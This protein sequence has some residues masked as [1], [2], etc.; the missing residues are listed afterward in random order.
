MSVARIR[1][2][3]PSLLAP[4]AGGARSFELEAETLAGA[5]DEA[6]RLH[7]ALRARLFDE[8]GDFRQH[9]L[10]FHNRTNSRWLE[11]REIALADGDTITFMQAVSGG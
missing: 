3:L 7:P 10:C 9:V 11:S 4:I 5:L 2:E 1:V 8:A 6:V